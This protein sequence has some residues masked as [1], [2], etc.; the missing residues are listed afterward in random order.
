MLDVTNVEAGQKK[1][2][3]GDAERSSESTSLDVTSVQPD[4]QPELQRQLPPLA[5]QLSREQTQQK[6]V[7]REEKQDECECATE[8]HNL[9]PR[10]KKINYKV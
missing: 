7:K 9:R 3:Q 1:T 5:Q 6:Q 10:D 8:T 2:N 4:A